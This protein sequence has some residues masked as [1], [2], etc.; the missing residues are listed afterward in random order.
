MSNS[1]T[2]GPVG[3]LIWAEPDEAVRRVTAP[4]LQGLATQTVQLTPETNLLEACKKHRGDL[5]IVSAA[6]PGLD[7][8]SFS[9]ILSRH[10]DTHSMSIMV[11]VPQGTDPSKVSRMQNGTIRDVLLHPILAPVLVERTRTLL[12]DAAARRELLSG[13]DQDRKSTTFHIEDNNSLLRRH[14]ACPFHL[15]P[16]HLDR[17][18]L[19][20][21]KIATELS[22]F[23]IPQYGAP[24]R[25]AD[26]INFHFLHIAVCP[27]CYFATNE[28]TY[29][30]DPHETKLQMHTFPPATQA[31]VAGGT[32]RRKALAAGASDRFFTVR[33]TLD[34]AIILH[35]LAI[36]SAITIYEANKYV[37][38]IEV[39]RIA[40]YYVRLAHLYELCDDATAREQAA[41]EAIDWLTKGFLFLEGAALCKA[42]YQL[43]ALNIS[44]GDDR[45]AFQYITRINE[46]AKEAATTE[47]DKATIARY[48][49]RLKS[50]WEDRDM[51]RYFV[52]PEEA[53]SDAA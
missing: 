8:G 35:R 50:I 3:R 43:V 28:P 12:R 10:P 44:T 6:W 5:L 26:A 30:S 24:A 18:I 53:T 27:Q 19:R 15:V 29:W 11:T 21:G 22:F 16:A 13:G 52:P 34:D 9:K 48:V 49:P 7:F 40:N 17:Y 37:L 1:S 25:G 46:I 39:L 33:R 14:V 20:T 31:I 36:D 42:I 32:E 23:D 51:H 4:L 2:S 38:P 41:R 45:A 47:E